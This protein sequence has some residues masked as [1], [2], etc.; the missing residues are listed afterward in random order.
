[1]EE[2]D[3]QDGNSSG[4]PGL[5]EAARELRRE[6]RTGRNRPGR[7]FGTV[8]AA[9]PGLLKRA[10]FFAFSFAAVAGAVLLLALPGLR[11]GIVEQ[12]AGLF[13]PGPDDELYKLPAPPPKAPNITQE[14]HFPAQA[15]DDDAILFSSSRPVPL[16]EEDEAE[17]SA[18]EPV[19]LPKSPGS[20]EAWAFL[21][22][23]EG[24]LGELLNDQDEK[25]EVKAWNL[26]K[27]APPVYFLD[28]VVVPA[29][30][31]SEQHFVFSVDL[32]QK[33]VN[34]L[35]QAARDFMAR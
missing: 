1:M 8:P 11:T 10:F 2:R 18:A 17:A 21:Q 12:A 32:G 16:A 29:G 31:T 9:G 23:V 24:P 26:V 35:S 13:I 33:A 5:E 7:E 4:S 22:Q 19:L 25:L 15:V 20:L 27:E 30:Q 3:Y 28:V 6:K 14:F 34:P